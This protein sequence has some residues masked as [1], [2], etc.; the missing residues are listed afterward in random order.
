VLAQTARLDPRRR[1]EPL[2]LE[3]KME[4][5]MKQII[6][7]SLLALVSTSAFSQTKL[8]TRCDGCNDQAAK[9]AAISAL[10][11]TSATIYVIDNPA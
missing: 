5:R 8:A 7:A 6:L 1:H 2:L 4:G 10:V 9:Q 11:G 3:L